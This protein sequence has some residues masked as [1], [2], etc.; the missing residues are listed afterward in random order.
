MEV[1][2]ENLAEKEL[3]AL[4]HVQIKNEQKV[5]IPAGAKKLMTV[6]C[7]LLNPK[8]EVNQSEILVVGNLNTRL[9]FI[10]ELGILS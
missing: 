6:T 4:D 7:Q 3:I 5:N 2:M 10:N 9:I 1:L 8:V